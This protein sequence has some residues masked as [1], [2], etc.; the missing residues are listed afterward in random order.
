MHKHRVLVVDDSQLLRQVLADALAPAGF[1]VSSAA[2][3]LEALRELRQRRPDLVI[4]DIIMPNM[5]GWA[6]CAEVR[7]DPAT[8]DIPFIFLTTE[9]DVPKRIKGLEMGADDYVVKPF[10]K[11]ELVA[12]ARGVMRRSGASKGGA[13]APEP[14]IALSGHTDHLPMPDLL[15]ALSL[16]GMSGTLHLA[17]ESLARVYFRAGQII[18]AETAGLKG[19]K[20]LFRI[21]AWPSARF[22]Y[23]PG[24][25]GRSVEAAIQGST[26]SVLMEGFAHLD[27]LRDLVAALPDRSRRLRVPPERAAELDRL[28][29]TT[30]QRLLLYAAG[31]RGATLAHL[32]DT[33]PEKD[34]DVYAALQEL[35]R[36]GLLEPAGTG[37]PSA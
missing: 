1:E 3:G 27:E 8:R 32:V 36:R 16:N 23:E 2:D 9:S 37:R 34:L 5:D 15:Q 12:R 33:A 11:E 14:E 20:A 22:E 6:L 26:S 24:E 25:P 30:T 10:S 28:E 19:E 21:M 7:R 4:A 29:L 17:G 18:N 35:V 13:A 31:Q